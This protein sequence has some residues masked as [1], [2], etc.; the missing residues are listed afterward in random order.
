[1]SYEQQPGWEKIGIGVPHPVEE[2]AEPE[3]AQP[4]VTRQSKAET[5]DKGDGEKGETAAAEG[6]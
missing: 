1:M 3:P 2:A 6:E 5:K 4:K